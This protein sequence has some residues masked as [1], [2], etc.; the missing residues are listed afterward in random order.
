M[1]KRPLIRPPLVLIRYSWPP[2][3]SFANGATCSKTCG[4]RFGHSRDLP[5]AAVAG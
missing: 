4:G 1:T 2:P 5:E 3:S